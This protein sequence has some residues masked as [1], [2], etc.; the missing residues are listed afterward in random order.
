MRPP[1]SFST[2]A[3]YSVAASQLVSWM[4]G[5]VIFITY[6]SSARAGATASAAANAKTDAVVAARNDM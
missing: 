3:A 5:S 1:E 6:W 2:R 4:V